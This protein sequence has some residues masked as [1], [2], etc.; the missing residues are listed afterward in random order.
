MSSRALFFVISNNNFPSKDILNKGNL[1]SLTYIKEKMEIFNKI[2][3]S[4]KRLDF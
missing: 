3:K 1:K 2:V 4:P